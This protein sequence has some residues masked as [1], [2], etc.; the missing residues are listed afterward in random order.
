MKWPKFE[1]KLGQLLHQHHSDLDVDELWTAIEPGVDHINKKKKKRRPWFWIFLIGLPISVACIGMI[2][3]KGGSYGNAQSSQATQSSSKILPKNIQQKNSKTNTPNR[4]PIIKSLFNK[5]TNKALNIQ[6]KSLSLN[7]NAYELKLHLQNTFTSVPNHDLIH[8]KSK[9]GKT[10]TTF[11]NSSSANEPAFPISMPPTVNIKHDEWDIPSLATKDISPIE[12]PI[13]ALIPNN[14]YWKDQKADW[15]ILAETGIGYSNRTLTVPPNDSVP[16][17]LMAKRNESET[18]LETVQAGLFVSRI[19]KKGLEITAGINYTQINERFKFEEVH[20]NVDYQ[21]GIEAFVN[22][23][24]NGLDTIYGLVPIQTTTTKRIINFNNHKIIDLPIIIG[25][26]R[27]L[28]RGQGSVGIRAGVFTNIYTQTEGKIFGYGNTDFE[29]IESDIYK[30]RVGLSYYMGLSL[31]YP[32]NDRI[33]I[34]LAPSV[35]YFPHSFTQGD[36]PLKQR[37]QVYSFKGGLR[38]RLNK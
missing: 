25:Y 14:D 19:H 2:Y 32:L 24:N 16:E 23:S 37:Y 27:P 10:F 18:Q 5:E 33:I 3:F 21:Y 8:V 9:P 7:S 15:F 31:N 1:D 30:R 35:R 13:E 17:A 34:S 38:F 12:Y 20:I 26:H 22:N 6:P 29:I 28:S 11:N 36:Y 4:T